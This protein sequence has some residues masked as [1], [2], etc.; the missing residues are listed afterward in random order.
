MLIETFHF[1]LRNIKG[2]EWGRTADIA[3][4]SRSEEQKS[5]LNGVIMMPPTM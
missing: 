5:G 3:K 4:M 1:D 2:L